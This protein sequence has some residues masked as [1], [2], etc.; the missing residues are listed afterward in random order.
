MK[1][2]VLTFIILVTP[3]FGYTQKEKQIDST[4]V[5]ILDQMSDLIGDLQSVTFNVN[6]SSDKLNDQGNITTHHSASYVSMVGPDKLI[7]K[8]KGDNGSHGF[9]YNGEYL[10]YYSY[11]ENNYLI[12]EAPD[13]LISMIDTMHARFDFKFPAADFF[14]PSFTDD[15]LES[16]DTIAFLGKRTIEEEEC[17]LIMAL[18]DQ[19]N[20]QLW[21]SNDNYFLP[22]KM[23]IIYKNQ[24]NM[25]YT[26]TFTSWVLNPQIPETIFEFMP[27][28]NAK[29]ISILEK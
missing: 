24:N 10:S 20:V 9:W 2:K 23:K 4:A 3:F 27:P 6:A 15:I 13:N 19:M 18:N 11:D 22:K 12:L 29:L 8:T 17:Y 28:P 21:V 7:A 16:F 1:N 25:H 26:T 14:Y 5:F